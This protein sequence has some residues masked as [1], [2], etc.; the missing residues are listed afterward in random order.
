MPYNHYGTVGDDT[1][2]GYDWGDDYIFGGPEYSTWRSDGAGRDT[3][4]GLGGNDNLYGGNNSDSLHG[5]AGND[6]L[7]GG[8]DNDSYFFSGDF[9]Q[10]LVYD[11]YDTNTIYFGDLY[12]SQ[13]SFTYDGGDLFIQKIGTLNR[14]LIDDYQ[15]NRSYFVIQFIDGV[16]NPSAS[17]NA[18]EGPDIITGTPY[19]DSIL[20]R[21]GNDTVYGGYGGDLLRGGLGD[22]YVYGN[23]DNDDVGG[24]DGNDWLDG[25]SGFDVVHGGPGRDTLTGGPDGDLFDY[26]AVSDSLLGATRR[27]LIR[28]FVRGV[29]DIDVSAIDANTRI[30]GDQGFSFIA[31][32]RFSAPGQI[33]SSV[34]GSQTIVQVSNDADTAAEMEIAL[35]GRFTLTASDFIL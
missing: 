35:A 18:T 25:G 21:G 14:V 34:S 28:D 9:G 6:Y 30:G 20:S 33:R 13:V 32:S 23:Q 3:L 5:G 16:W 2:Y 7:S 17:F 24:A 11:Y 31:G 4:Y 12:K 19:A 27:D 29:D 1:V 26:G 8:Y 10:D 15:S 22:D